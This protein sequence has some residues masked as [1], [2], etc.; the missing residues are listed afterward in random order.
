MS[1]LKVK[2]NQSTLNT[3]L[4]GIHDFLSSKGCPE[5]LKTLITIAAEE[6]YVNIARYAYGDAEG[7]AEVEMDIKPNTNCYRI[8]FR[9][10]GK[11]FN[12]LEQKEP[13]FNLAL[14]EKPIGGLGI[15]MVREMMD[16]VEYEYIDGHNVLTMEKN[17]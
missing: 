14:E 12:P 7:E 13:D 6:I 4:D 1:G 2:A 3:V 15:F 10:K 8:T 9:D 16:K 11:P 17:T 5:D